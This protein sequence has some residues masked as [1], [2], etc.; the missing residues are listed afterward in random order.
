MRFYLRAYHDSKKK[1]VKDCA[2]W[3]E[4]HEFKRDGQ[5]MGP[6]VP[7]KPVKVGKLLTDKPHRYMWYQ[8]TI[9]LF[10]NRVVGPFDFEAGNRVPDAVWKELL[11]KAQDLNLYVGAVNRVVA[12]DK[13]DEQDVSKRTTIQSYMSLRWN[14]MDGTIT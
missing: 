8:D 13:P 7:V 9:N 1:K 14:T 2:Y 11:S 6:I 12:L 5:T 10:Q 4:I 3:P